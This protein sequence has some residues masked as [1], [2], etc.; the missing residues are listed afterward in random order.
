LFNIIDP[1]LNQVKPTP[2]RPGNPPQFPLNMNFIKADEDFGHRLY[3]HAQEVKHVK[4]AADIFSISG[5][6]VLWF[7]GPAVFGR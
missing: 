5:D 2:G 1:K 7:G 6:E 3:K 4:L